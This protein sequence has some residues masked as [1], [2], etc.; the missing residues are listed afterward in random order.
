MRNFR[1]VKSEVHEWSNKL[2]ARFFL[3]V[4]KIVRN[5]SPEYRFHNHE[6]PQFFSEIGS[7][8]S[9]VICTFEDRF[10]KFALPLIKQIRNESDLPIILIVNG[11]LDRPVS[12]SKFKEFLAQVINF[13][14]VYPVTFTSFQGCAKMWNS[15][16]LH[17]DSEV[18]IIL[19]DD[20]QLIPGTLQ[21]D[22]SKAVESAN[23]SMV[24]RINGSWSHFVITK[25]A[26][27][28]LGWFDE[29]FLG[30]GEEDGDYQ[31]RYSSHFSREIPTIRLM[32]FV[33]LIDSSR[34]EGIAKGVSKYSLFNRTLVSHNLF[35][36][37]SVSEARALYPN[38]TWREA[39]LPDLKVSSIETLNNLLNRDL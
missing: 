17:A 2:G 34:D 6:T 25:K 10:F 8:A 39:H 1:V 30:I 27:N 21:A 26:I 35:R 24:V 36:K 31:T 22:L 5:L 12:S 16:I 18:V 13:P 20:L 23:S 14:N 33:N 7:A 9:I 11:N 38:W 3:S 4:F 19:N 28:V 32:S 37:L 15:G 29:R